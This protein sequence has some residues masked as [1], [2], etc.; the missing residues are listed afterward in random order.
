[1]DER[2]ETVGQQRLQPGEAD[3]ERAAGAGTPGHDEDPERRERVIA[4]HLLPHGESP[5]DPRDQQPR[6]EQ[7][8]PH[9]TPA[10][11][12]DLLRDEPGE[13]GAVPLAVEHQAVHGAEEE[14]RDE[15][16]EKGQP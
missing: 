14:E 12:V 4:S 6:P 16:V 11:A 10:G 5:A 2:R 3:T 7:Q 8:R 13:A 1:M 15:D 9:R